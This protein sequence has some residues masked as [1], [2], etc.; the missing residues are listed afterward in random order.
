MVHMENGI[1][2]SH[3]KECSNDICSNMMQLGSLIRSEVSQN[4][5]HHKISF[6]CGI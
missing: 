6:I 4:D 1:L 2:L 3:V 5:K